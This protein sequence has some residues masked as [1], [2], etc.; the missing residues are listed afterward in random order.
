MTKLLVVGC[1]SI[2]RRHI[3]NFRAAG[4]DYIGGADTRQDRL[5]QANEQH[6]L[7]GSW[8]DYRD[9][10]AQESFDAVAVTTPPHLHTEIAQAAAEAG[11]HLLIEK[12]L[13]KDLNGLDQLAQTL[14]EKERLCFVAYCYRF[15]PS[16]L[17]MREVVQSG[18]L[19]KVYAARLQ[20]SSYLPDWHPW[21]DYRTFYMA[22]KEQGGGALLDD[23]HGIDLMRWLFGEVVSVNAWVGNVSNLEISSDDLA[24]MRMVFDSGVRGEAHFDLMGRTPRLSLEIIGSEGTLLWDRIDHKIEVFDADSKTWQVFPYTHNDLMSMYP[25]EVAHFL[26]CLRGEEQPLVDL[27]D[28]RKTL[29]VLMAAFR[30]SE[31][32]RDVAL[33]EISGS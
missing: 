17:K 5:D 3:G 14:Q 13:A 19:G 10:L 29:S 18:R 31:E 25:N 8:L 22:K 30:S 9:A 23:S 32:G 21:E 24:T 27:A 1:G 7:D 11:C 28:A 26:G 33:T 4:V 20:F 2:G 16:V 6:G 12:P 15:I